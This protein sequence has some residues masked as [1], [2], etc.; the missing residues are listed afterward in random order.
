MSTF[1][2]AVFKRRLAAGWTYSRKTM[3]GHLRNLTVGRVRK[4]K[5]NL[6]SF[7]LWPA[8]LPASKKHLLQLANSD[9]RF[10][11]KANLPERKASSILLAA[12]WCKRNLNTFE[13]VL[14]SG[15]LPNNHFRKGTCCNWLLHIKV[16]AKQIC[17]N[18]RYFQPC[19]LPL[20]A[21]KMQTLSRKFSLQSDCNWTW[22]CKRIWRLSN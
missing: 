3:W 4:T 13:E 19:W 8:H 15:A 7:I 16:S 5:E 10:Q 2:K 9:K 22:P 20:A 17:R 1:E 11:P 21:Y 18:A 6:L 12:L 14:N